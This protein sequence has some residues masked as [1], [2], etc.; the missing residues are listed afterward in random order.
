VTPDAARR[1]LIVANW[2]MNGLRR[3]GLD[4]ARALAARAA[5]AP[6]LGCDIVLC[7]PA[8][9]LVEV[10][11]A[12]DGSPLALGAQDCHAEPSGA[13]TG[14]LAAPM[15]ADAG[16]G[17]VIVGHSERR[18]AHG[19]TDAAVAAKASA[20]QRA[21]LIPIVCVGEDLAAR[22]AGRAGAVVEAQ[23]LASLPEPG[24]ALVVA[25]EPIWAIGTGRTAA[26]ADIAAMHALIRAC[27]DP[28]FPGGGGVVPVLYGGS[29]NAR[30]AADVLAVPGVGGALV[31]GASLVVDEFWAICAAAGRPAD[32]R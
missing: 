15:L 4:R 18:S 13:H 31:G 1:P 32:C 2:K 23:L 7:P 10:R 17:Y 20:A 24:A 16:C 30:N 21:G 3:D 6:S 14:D 8:T 27:L 19:E 9:L 26:A 5:A 25:Y 12:L 22:D 11:A 28:H 29:V